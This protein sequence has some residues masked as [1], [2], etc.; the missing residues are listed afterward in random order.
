MGMGLA[1][2]RHRPRSL[3]FT[4]CSACSTTRHKEK[5]CHPP[6]PHTHSCLASE[7]EE[8]SCEGLWV[9]PAPLLHRAVSSWCRDYSPQ[10]AQREA[11]PLVGG[12]LRVR[13][14]VVLCRE[15]LHSWRADRRPMVNLSGPSAP[16]TDLCLPWKD[17][18]KQQV[19][20]SSSCLAQVSE[21]TWN[22]G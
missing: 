1:A 18:E 15:L 14:P 11:E 17:S 8:F 7:P 21:G 12:T 6:H 4:L 20:M 10:R 2:P 22:P 16:Q 9:L 19:P 13:G 3:C 5:Q